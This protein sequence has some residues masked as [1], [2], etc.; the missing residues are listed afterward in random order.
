MRT[1]SE[2]HIEVLQWRRTAL[3]AEV[4]LGVPKRPTVLELMDTGL[5]FD[6]AHDARHGWSEDAAAEQFRI[7]EL[8]LQAITFLLDLWENL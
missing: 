8:E 7:A 4:L 2:A 6:Q 5:G 3:A 1:L